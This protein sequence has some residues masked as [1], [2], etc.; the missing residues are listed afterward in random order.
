M[1]KKFLV[2]F[3]SNKFLNLFG[4]SDIDYAGTLIESRTLQKHTNVVDISDF[5][6]LVQKNFDF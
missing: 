6:I 3:K 2:P 4:V 1:N 5:S